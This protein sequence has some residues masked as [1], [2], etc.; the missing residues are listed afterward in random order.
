MPVPDLTELLRPVVK[1]KNR[2]L[3]RTVECENCTEEFTT[4]IATRRFCSRR[5]QL[6]SLHGRSYC[7]RCRE[8]MEDRRFGCYCCRKCRN[9]DL[10]QAD[11]SR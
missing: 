9:A 8:M 3:V 7:K 1:P 10:R 6:G 11:A 5:C 2:R 4:E